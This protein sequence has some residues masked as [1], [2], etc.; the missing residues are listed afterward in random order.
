MILFF[1]TLNKIQ[2]KLQKK[3]LI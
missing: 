1:R 3:V 2:P